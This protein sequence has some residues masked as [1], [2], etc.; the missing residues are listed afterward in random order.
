MHTAPVRY[1]NPNPASS[2]TDWLGFGPR[3]AR[4]ELP[5]RR[6]PPSRHPRTVGVRK[7]LRNFDRPETKRKNPWVNT[8]PHGRSLIGWGLKRYSAPP[9]ND[10]A[11]SLDQKYLHVSTAPS[12]S[13]RK[14]S[15]PPCMV[16][17]PN[18]AGQS[19]IGLSSKMKRARP[20]DDKVPSPDR[21]CFHTST[22][23]TSWEQK[24][25][26]TGSAPSLTV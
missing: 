4:R 22:T 18:L 19:L 10:R 7:S 9:G 20:T 5:L 8:A 24:M 26:F 11:P 23:P 16:W 25:R 12:I 21:K 15:S 13:G 2:I 3:R 17:K 6:T 1:G 14:R